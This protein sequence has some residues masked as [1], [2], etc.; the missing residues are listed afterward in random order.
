MTTD[1]VQAVDC[2]SLAFL[3]DLKLW[4]RKLPLIILSLHWSHYMVQVEVWRQQY[5]VWPE[6]ERPVMMLLRIRF[7]HNYSSAFES[8]GLVLWP[9]KVIVSYTWLSPQDILF[10]HHLFSPDTK[11]SPQRLFVSG[12]WSKGIFQKMKTSVLSCTLRPPDS[13]GATEEFRL[14]S[15]PPKQYTDVAAEQKEISDQAWW[16]QIFLHS[17]V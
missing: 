15:M 17:T 10:L 4:K 6:L 9:W 13:H 3:P 7:C 16:E 2:P 8:P 1:T 14:L 12:A 5:C 11:V